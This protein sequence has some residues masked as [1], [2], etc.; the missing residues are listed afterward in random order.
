[1]L[2]TRHAQKNLLQPVLSYANCI[3]KIGVEDCE[4]VYSEAAMHLCDVT[5]TWFTC[6][7]RDL[8]LFQTSYRW[9][10]AARVFFSWKSNQIWRNNGNH[11]GEGERDMLVL[12]HEVEGRL[13][14]QS[15]ERH[16]IDLVVYGDTSGDTAMA[17]SVGYPCAI[18]ARMVLLG[19]LSCTVSEN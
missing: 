12:R 16:A 3:E 13:K 10:A 15:I 19:K 18:A 7:H 17:K 6:V 14:D 2:D 4:F 1:M 5:N 11:T 8:G 9:N